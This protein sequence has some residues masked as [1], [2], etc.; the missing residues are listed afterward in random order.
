V[1]PDGVGQTIGR[2]RLNKEVETTRDREVCDCGSSCQ[3]GYLALR[4]LTPQYSVDHDTG[5]WCDVT[6]S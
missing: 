5:L 4:F 6:E 1:A 2:A 3:A